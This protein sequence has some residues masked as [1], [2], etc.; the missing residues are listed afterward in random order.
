MTFPTVK[1]YNLLRRARTLPADFQ[2]RLNIVF[3]PFYQWQQAQVNSWIPLARHLEYEFDGVRYYEL[4]TIQRLNPVAQT[5]INEGMRAG[6]SDQTA[7]ERTI[8]LYVNK[9]DF[10]SA[11]GLPNEDEI[12]VLLVDRRGNILWKDRGWFTPQKGESLSQALGAILKGD[13]VPDMFI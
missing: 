11:L 7:R 4:P 5:F 12:H 13:K 2:G 10:R 6:I 1:G 8:T 3:I 9:L